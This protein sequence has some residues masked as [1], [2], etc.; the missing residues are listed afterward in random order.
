MTSQQSFVRVIFPLGMAFLFVVLWLRLPLGVPWGAAAPQV[1]FLRI[2][3]VYGGGGNSGSLYQNDFVELYNNSGTAINLNG[4]SVQYAGSSSDSWYVTPLGDVDIEANSYLLIKLAQGS[5]GSI[6]LPTADVTGTTNLA[7]S[8]GKVALV[9]NETELEGVC[10]TS[11]VD[12]VGYGSAN[13]FEGTAASSGASNTASLVR[14]DAG[15]MDSDD[16]AVDFLVADP[17]VPRNSAA[18]TYVCLPALRLELSKS[19]SAWVSLGEYF[20][21]TLTVTNSTGSAVNKLTLTDTLPISVTFDEA[22]NEGVLLGDVISWSIGGGFLDGA[23][24]T[25]TF[26]VLAEEPGSITNADYA[27]RAATWATATLGKLV[28]TFVSPLDLRVA[29]GGPVYGVIGEIFT[30][31]ISL[32]TQGVIGTGG[33]VLTDTF[34]AGLR[35]LHD[36]SGFM[37][38]EVA[39]NTWVW[40]LSDM[41]ANTTRS[42]SVTVAVAEDLS[43]GDSLTNQISVSCEQLGDDPSNNVA[44]M[45]TQVYPL[46]PIYDIQYVPQPE[47]DDAS[48]YTGQVVWVDGLV[49]AEPGEI[50]YEMNNLVIA[51][52]SGGAWN[53]LMVYQGDSFAALSAP[54][55][56][57][58]RLLGRIQEYHGM[59]EI[60]IRSAP[61]AM[62]LLEGSD[63]L[64]S[65]VSLQTS[66][67]VT[68]TQV[69]QWEGVL[70]EFADAV[71]NQKLDDGR[72]TCK[73]DGIATIVD[74]YGRMDGDLTYLPVPGERLSFVRGIGWYDNG[75]YQLQ[76]RYDSDIAVFI[77]TPV[78]TKVAPAYVDPGEL[79]TYTLMLE[80]KTG[81]EL[82][83][84]TIT[85]VLP[86]NGSLAAILDGGLLDD[87]MITWKISNLPDQAQVQV[88]FAVTAAVDL[89]IV[90]WNEH[91]AVVAGNYLT[92]TYGMPLATTI[93][94]YTPIPAIQGSGGASRF[95]HQVV[96]SRGVVVGIF[97]GNYSA[98]G[99]FDGFFLQDTVGD[100]DPTTSDGIFVNHGTSTLFY[101]IGDEIIITGTVQEFDEYGAAA[102]QGDCL[103]QV[104]INALGYQVIGKG[105]ITPAELI[106]LGEPLTAAAYFESL[107]GMLVQ[108][109][110]T[111]TV[112]G[113]TSHGAVT[114]IPGNE[115][116]TRVLRY[117][118]QEGM[119]FA[120]RHW[121]RYGSYTAPGLSVGSAIDGFLGPF[122][123]SYAGYMVVTQ[124]GEFWTAVYTQELPAKTP[125]WPEPADDQFSVAT[126]NVYDF[127]QLG[128]KLD[129]VVQA[130]R[131]MNG[132][133][134]LAIQEISPT[135]AMSDFIGDLAAVGYEYEYAYSYPSHGISVAL[136]WRSDLITQNEWIT[137]QGC[138]PDGSSAANYDPMWEACRSQGMYPTFPRRPVVLTATL[139]LTDT[140]QQV[141]VIANHLKSKLGGEPSD[142][143]RLAEAEFLADLVSDFVARGQKYVI[144]LGDLND[145]ED[146]SP[147]QALY[148]S[149]MLTNTWYTL[150]PDARYSYIYHGV[151]Q[152]LDHLLLTPA[153][154]AQLQ[155]F[156]PL[157]FNADYPYYP[158][159]G[160]GDVVWHTSDH[161]PLIATF[162]ISSSELSTDRV[163]LP[164]LM[165]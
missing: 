73:N 21:Y 75:E 122:T 27:V 124:P 30:Y 48:S 97:E 96:T 102:C 82:T 117:S 14:R 147:L 15:C 89:G 7:A 13:C 26:R 79:F 68:G 128:V 160:D 76:P 113:P 164:L 154:K 51:D 16:N 69:E 159:A 18:D 139:T 4:W 17:P 40:A 148:A 64:P 125:V 132:P 111:A 93:G 138:S 165:R 12:F 25:R 84:V 100:G 99:V 133:A 31:Q 6:L 95:E 157:H 3:Q 53:G 56:A 112:V 126:F 87:D 20:T 19:A 140:S 136:L 24:L 137:V 98:G 43:G 101:E 103:T 77:N 145:Y 11:V 65:P 36:T 32:T 134:F 115:P 149:G 119:P 151:S 121:V 161:D 83:N 86:E 66:Q 23:V 156:S 29:V 143:M 104:R 146:S 158:Y 116:V 46:V 135:V 92:P 8:N 90:I 155:S 45:T 57:R 41:A 129:K 37:P 110:N 142:W 144:V 162:E 91:Y 44:S 127:D 67:F 107:E 72:W 130:V 141:I 9:E 34:P 62:Q 88:H 54:E 2:S 120:V 47:V 35:Y 106:P 131:Q 50:G 59:T 74:D 108:F 80:N 10:P 52:P 38:F 81:I 60:N 150:P 61:H 71:V 63:P 49:I 85:D 70:I 118:P 42:F 55:G 1:D 78:L 152:A 39:P 123:W 58:L 5:G 153:L 94:S 105:N 114:V 163:Y 33:V 109:P 22:S 28:E